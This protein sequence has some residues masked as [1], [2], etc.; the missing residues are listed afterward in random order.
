MNEQIVLIV[1]VLISAIILFLTIKILQRVKRNTFERTGNASNTSESLSFLSDA[2]VVVDGAGMVTDINPVFKSTFTDFKFRPSKTE[3]E[4]LKNYLETRT[5]NKVPEDIFWVLCIHNKPISNAEITIEIDGSVRR[6][7]LSKDIVTENDRYAGF[8]ITLNDVSDY[9]Q[10]IDDINKN[11]L[12]EIKNAGEAFL[13]ANNTFFENILSNEIRRPLSAITG[14][15]EIAKR[16]EDKESISESLDK[17]NVAAT[18]LLKIVNNTADVSK[19][20]SGHFV[21]Y[22]E[23]FT[24]MNMIQNIASF[25][26]TQINRKNQK[27]KILID[28]NIPK[29]IVADESRLFDVINNLLSNAINFTPHGGNIELSVNL[30]STKDQ[31]LRLRIAVKDDGIGISDNMR[32]KLFTVFKHFDSS[33]SRQYGGT[34]FGLAISQKIIGL[35]GGVISM[36]SEPGKGSIFTFEIDA[37][38]P[39]E[40][41][42]HSTEPAERDHFDEKTVYDFSGYTILLVE[43]VNI[44]RE[45]VMELLKDTGV[46]FECAEN[47]LSAVK[48]YE[49]DPRKYDMIYMDIQMP[50]L[51]GYGAAQKIRKKDTLIPIVAMTADAT[52]AD[53]RKCKSFGMD[54]HIAKPVDLKE[55]L[56]KTDMYLRK[57]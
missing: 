54:D 28:N 24:F 37:H 51:D 1:L 35:M 10:V 14:M 11:N 38:V 46:R 36:K 15:A 41:H 23:P 40:Q 50:I 30:L 45:I 42:D 47:G 19:L 9:R 3:V 53:I 5:L 20:E 56:S 13:I 7:L 44:N 6:Y 32:P 12:A 27:F 39:T 55:L 57:K 8:I 25:N 18:S 52:V 49:A 22:E 16:A 17:I 29:V 2:C 34:A 21:L 4:E 31:S 33:Y 43:D 26:S 48:M